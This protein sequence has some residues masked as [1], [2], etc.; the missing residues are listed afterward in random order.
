VPARPAADLLAGLLVRLADGERLLP[1][2]AA[3]RH[4]APPTLLDRWALAAHGYG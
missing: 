3:A 1:A 2:L 4:Q